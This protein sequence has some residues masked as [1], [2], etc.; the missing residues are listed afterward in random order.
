MKTKNS[1]EQILEVKNLN[2]SFKDEQIIK[3][4]NFTLK[5]GEILTIIGPNGAGKTTLLRSLLDILPY[6]GKITWKKGLKINYLPQ[7]L[8]KDKF[9]LLPIS[10]KEFFKLKHYSKHKILDFLTEVGLPNDIR[11]LNKTPDKLSSGQFQRLLIAWSLI[12]KPDVL[13]FDEP[14]TGLDIGGEH[15]IYSLLKQL[16]KKYNLTIIIITHDLDIVYT[17][18][19]TCLCLSK[20]HVCHGSPKKVLTT[21][22]LQKMYGS[23]IKFYEH[24]H[25]D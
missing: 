22:A 14:T 10:I 16:W 23:D 6:S 3:N 1:N 7:S 21:Q 9:K 17:Y 15:T 24:I 8:S 2:V 25:G 5:Q 19:N 18:S 11:F 4:L 12:D 13:L 20:K